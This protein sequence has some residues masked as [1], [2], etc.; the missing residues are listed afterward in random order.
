MCSI[1]VCL[2]PSVEYWHSMICICFLPRY[3]GSGMNCPLKLVVYPMAL[4]RF[5]LL[6]VGMC[7]VE[8]YILVWFVGGLLCLVCHFEGLPPQGGGFVVVVLPGLL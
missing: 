5:G 3:V 7:C 4:I 1:I 6:W 8:E 2:F